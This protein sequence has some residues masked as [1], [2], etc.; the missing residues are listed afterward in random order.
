MNSNPKKIKPNLL[1]EYN[2][3]KRNQKFIENKT[4]KNLN[5][6]NKNKFIKKLKET[7]NNDDNNRETE[8]YVESEAQSNINIKKPE[9]HRNYYHNKVL[10]SNMNSNIMRNTNKAFKITVGIKPEY[11]T[12]NYKKVITSHCSPN[13][14]S[15]NFYYN[16]QYYKKIKKNNEKPLDE[17]NKKK[18]VNYNIIN[19]IQDNSTQINIYTGSELYKSLH[20]HN[21]SVF[22]SPNITPGS[23]TFSRSP[24][25]KGIEEKVKSKGNIPQ[26][27]YFKQQIKG[28]EKNKYNLNLKKVINKRILESEREKYLISERL[29]THNKLLE[30]LERYFLKNNND[31]NINHTNIKINNYNS[32]NNKNINHNMNN[33][34]KNN[35]RNNILYNNY[36]KNSSNDHHKLIKKIIS[37]DYNNLNNKHI[38][39]KTNNNTPLKRDY[40]KY[41]HDNQ[42]NVCISPQNNEQFRKIS[43][44]IKSKKI[45]YNN[46]INK[47]NDFNNIGVEDSNKFLINSERNKNYKIIFN[48]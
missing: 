4:Q 45:N 25:G 2:S 27:N 34:S 17:F 28:K 36:T 8:N 11:L 18:V 1:V 21:N 7:Q 42:Q 14:S 43:K 5:K 19:N 29:M 41:L 30:K 35:N 9:S 38:N 33:N 40:N 10:S 32:N 6:S 47:L 39:N 15:S 48:K 24:I 22:N 13:S 26:K 46:L 12:Q 16:S 3:A 31:N 37:K 44:P 23:G 20:F